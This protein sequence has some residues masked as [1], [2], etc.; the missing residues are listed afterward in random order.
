M[1][2]NIHK[3]WRMEGPGGYCLLMNSVKVK[4]GGTVIA[5]CNQHF[6]FLYNIFY[7]NAPSPLPPKLLSKNSQAPVL[8]CIWVL[9]HS[10]GRSCSEKPRTE[11]LALWGR[12]GAVL[13]MHHCSPALTWQ[14]PDEKQG[15]HGA[16]AG[17]RFPEQ[18]FWSKH[19][20]PPVNSTPENSLRSASLWFV[21]ALVPPCLET[22]KSN[23]D[24][25]VREIKENTA[26]TFH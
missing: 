26:Q 11:L 17:L 9:S 4:P 3:K 14:S 7:L 5:I 13:G 1:S 19:S 20:T 2:L 6:W 22:T 12:Q 10:L 21:I 25:L 24:L 18:E 8:H 15:A 16:G 23:P